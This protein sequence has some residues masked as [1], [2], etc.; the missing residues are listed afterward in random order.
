MKRFNGPASKTATHRPKGL[1]FNERKKMIITQTKD[2]LRGGGTERGKFLRS[3]RLRKKNGLGGEG[4]SQEKVC[5]PLKLQ[6][7][8]NLEGKVHPGQ[9]G[10]AKGFC[11]ARDVKC[12][13]RSCVKYI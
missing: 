1:R 11:I 12:V 6:G 7:E 9:K 2:L 13:K 8:R 10:M 3:Y 5:A 4:E